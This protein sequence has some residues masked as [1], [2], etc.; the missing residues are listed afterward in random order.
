MKL[1]MKMPVILLVA[2]L[3]GCASAD[4]PLQL[5]AGE[6][7]RYPSQ[8]RADGIEGEVVVGYDVTAAGQVANAFVISAQPAGLFDAAALQA[9][10]SWQFK[11]PVVAGVSQAVQGLQSTVM[12]RLGQAD[13]Y[14]KY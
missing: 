14:D 11:A 8:A 5:L 2:A 1:L 10:R 3:L 9:V 7:P 6:G 12:F 4:R 13:E